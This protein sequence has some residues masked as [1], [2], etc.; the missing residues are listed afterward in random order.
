[1]LKS[2]ID[3]LDKH[4]AVIVRM[5]AERLHGT[6]TVRYAVRIALSVREERAPDCLSDMARLAASLNMILRYETA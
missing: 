4:G 5:N 3:V 1:M 6:T 2:I